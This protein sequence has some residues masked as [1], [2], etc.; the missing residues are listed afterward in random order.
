MCV[1]MPHSLLNV[2]LHISRNYF[3]LFFIFFTK[4]RHIYIIRAWV[5]H[6]V[7]VDERFPFFIFETLTEFLLP[8]R[9]CEKVSA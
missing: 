3:Y 6:W 1:G 5:P 4:T 8:W 2:A 9:G 7:H